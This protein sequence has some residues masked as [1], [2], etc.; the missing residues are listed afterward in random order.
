[1][2]NPFHPTTRP[3]MCECLAASPALPEKRSVLLGLPTIQT[4]QTHQESG[5]H[6][7]NSPVVLPLLSAISAS[8][9]LHSVPTR[10][11][12]AECSIVS[13]LSTFQQ[14]FSS[15]TYRT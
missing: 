3:A 6:P 10:D 7:R 13:P 12:V 4:R 8:G 2:L 15:S 5:A 9:T 14:T 1:M 11:R